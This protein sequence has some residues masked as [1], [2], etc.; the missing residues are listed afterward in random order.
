M[1]KLSE[2]LAFVA[3]VDTG[4]ISEAARRLGTAKSMVSQRIQ[5]LEKRLGCILLERGRLT[6]LTESGEVF[7]RHCTG[8]LAD[9][10]NAENAVLTS[11]S[12]V[13]GNLRVAA[14][15]AFGM[16][17]LTPILASFA[18]QYPELSLDV[19]FDD[20]RV[21]LH[22]EGFD[23]AVRIGELPDSSLVAKTITPNRHII[24]ASP[25]YLNAHGTPRT[26]QDLAQHFAMLYVNREPHG[27]W[28]LPVN[29]T[30][31]SFRV[32][33]RMRTN[34]GHQLMEAAKAG[35]GLAILPTFLAAQAIVDG[36]LIEVLEPYA[37]RGGNI[38]VVY[39]QSQRASPKLRALSSFLSEQI[40]NPPI[41]DQ[42]LATSPQSQL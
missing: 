1:N 12:S 29:D 15:M 38:S 24:C 31:E 27:M 40:G 3:V 36:E 10:E 14:P 7:Y 2:M 18:K 39:R 32:R 26:P 21:N 19:E 23:A 25:D 35:L 11:Q 33:C 28:T 20:R 16:R 30:L 37:P 6:R 42:M 5:Q 4:S 9:I 17:Y 13:R 22:E 41:W 34:C 8:I